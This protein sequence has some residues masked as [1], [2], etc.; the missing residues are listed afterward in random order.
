[1]AELPRAVSTDHEFYAHH[2][3]QL[4]RIADAIAEQNE[5]LR[6]VLAARQADQPEP[7]EAPAEPGVPVAVELREPDA[8][9]KTTRPAPLAEPEPASADDKKPT[10]TARG[11]RRSTK[12]GT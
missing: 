10:R 1:M 7:T 6:Q 3:A 2:S 12:A 5:L 8:P 11:G 9:S 4:I